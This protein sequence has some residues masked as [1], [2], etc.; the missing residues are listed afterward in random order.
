M[1]R[2]ISTVTELRPDSALEGLLDSVKVT[3]KYKTH[4]TLTTQTQSE[5]I[6]LPF[7]K[8]SLKISCKSFKQ[9]YLAVQNL[10][11]QNLYQINRTL[12]SCYVQHGISLINLCLKK[13]RHLRLVA[14]GHF[15][16][17]RAISGHHIDQD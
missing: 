10:S 13:N 14:I 9:F 8:V 3:F 7:V 6:W 2:I 5:Q 16:V 17:C 15:V 11:L 12:C 1:Y 4:L